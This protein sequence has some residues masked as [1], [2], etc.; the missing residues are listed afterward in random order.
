A[1]ARID[2]AF[3]RH[4]VLYLSNVPLP[5]SQPADAFVA[6]RHLFALPAHTKKSALHQFTHD[7]T[8]GYLHLGRETLNRARAPDVREAYNLQ[9]RTHVPCTYARDAY[10]PSFEP[11][12]HGLFDALQDVAQRFSVAC[13]LALQLPLHVFA[14][15]TRELSQTTLRLAHYPAC[16]FDAQH[17]TGLKHDGAAIRVG[18]HTDYGLFS[19]LLCDTDGLQ[20]RPPRAPHAMWY[21][22]PRAPTA[23]GV[24]VLVTP[25]ALTARFTNDLWPATLHRVVVP[26][27]RVAAHS[28]YSL[29]FFLDPDKNCVVE[30]NAQLLRRLGDV[31]PKYAPVSAGA[32]E[33]ARMADAVPRASAT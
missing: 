3:R 6:A 5:P 1:A 2:D 14:R 26:S 21:D 8:H 24:C 9:N 25:G 33:N 32:Y 31:A 12:A 7:S 13:A 22:V 17:S 23:C 18:E 4:G 28:R 29:V 15:L 11:A 30:P 19:L 27:P 16:H 10:P 20:I